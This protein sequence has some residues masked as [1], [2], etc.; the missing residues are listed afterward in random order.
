MCVKE[1]VRARARER[2]SARARE[3]ETER[4]SES[5][6]ARE[7]ERER[8]F[9]INAFRSGLRVHRNHPASAVQASRLCLGG[10]VRVPVLG[11]LLTSLLLSSLELSDTQNL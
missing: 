3:R 6:R 11:C 4:D 5:A 2:E 1:S 7:R 10:G 9:L 8:F